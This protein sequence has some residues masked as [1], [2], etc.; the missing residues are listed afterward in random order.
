[1][2]TRYKIN[3][4]FLG[5]V[6]NN[7]FVEDIADASLTLLVL[8]Y[9]RLRIGPQQVAEEALIWDVCWP[10]YHLDVSVVCQLLT[11]TAVHTKNL[12]IY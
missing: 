7:I 3:V 4:E 12:I 2:P 10:L 5:K 8:G 9:L 1:M 11:Q 6:S